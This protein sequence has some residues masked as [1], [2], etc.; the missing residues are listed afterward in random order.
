MI[1]SQQKVTNMIG[2]HQ[3][4]PPKK[5]KYLKIVVIML[6]MVNLIQA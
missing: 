5:L 3:K 6:L 1:M 2:I 4:Y